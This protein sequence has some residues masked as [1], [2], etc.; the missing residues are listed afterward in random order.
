MVDFWVG[1]FSGVFVVSSSF[2]RFN[3]RRR[4]TG[5]TTADFYGDFDARHFLG[6]YSGLGLLNEVCWHLLVF[7]DSD[8]NEFRVTQIH[9][10]DGIEAG[11]KLTGSEERIYEIHNTCKATHSTP[12]TG[13][14][15]PSLS[16]SLTACSAQASQAK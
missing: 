8:G 15:N 12:H 5:E 1:F 4:G 10:F 13:H 9:M 6:F 3:E 14:S 16:A 7:S 11:S 2:R